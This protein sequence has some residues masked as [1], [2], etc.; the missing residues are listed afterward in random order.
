MKIELIKQFRVEYSVY[1]SSFMTEELYNIGDTVEIEY[2]K[3]KQTSK[4]EIITG[5]ISED[6][7][8]DKLIID[9]SE[10]FNSKKM[11]VSNYYIRGIKKIKSEE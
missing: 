10:K 8:K 3:E 11:C 2:T 1:G 5:R 9:Y 4:H 7:D 6:S